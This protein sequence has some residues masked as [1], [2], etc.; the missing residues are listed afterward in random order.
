MLLIVY[1]K[2]IIKPVSKIMGR[3]VIILEANNGVILT[4]I[5]IV[6]QPKMEW[7]ATILGLECIWHMMELI[8]AQ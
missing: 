5:Q 4:I 8:Q 1:H 6:V 2:I 3:Y 7:L